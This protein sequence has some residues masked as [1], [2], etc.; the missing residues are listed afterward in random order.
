MSRL[1]PLDN[2]QQK[3]FINNDFAYNETSDIIKTGVLLSFTY[4]LH[5]C[6]NNLC[7]LALDITIHRLR[8]L[9]FINVLTS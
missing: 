8:N 2:V 5:K 7:E 1:F 6:R 4:T 3:L 9:N